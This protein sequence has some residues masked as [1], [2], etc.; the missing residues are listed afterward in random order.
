MDRSVPMPADMLEL[1]EH[2]LESKAADFDPA[3]FEDHYHTALIEL[4]QRKRAGLP[5]RS[6][7]P[8]PAPARVIKPH[9][10]AARSTLGLSI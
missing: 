10:G 4:L 8:A 9:G 1:A 7:P 6:Q 3:K 2:I 5:M